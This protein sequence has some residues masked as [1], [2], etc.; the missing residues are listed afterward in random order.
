MLLRLEAERA[1]VQD[2]TG[3]GQPASAPLVAV[4]PLIA[5]AAGGVPRAESLSDLLSSRAEVRWGHRV[6]RDTQLFPSGR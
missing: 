2:K 1:G 3:L 4:L 6:L 5:D